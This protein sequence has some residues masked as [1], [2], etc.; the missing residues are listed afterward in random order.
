VAWRTFS[1]AGCG[2]HFDF[3]D[4]L[5]FAESLGPSLGS[6]ALSDVMLPPHLARHGRTGAWA[7]G[8]TLARAGFCTL[9]HTLRFL[10]LSASSLLLHHLHLLRRLL[11]LL[12]LHFAGEPAASRGGALKGWNWYPRSAPGGLGRA[13]ARIRR[14]V[15]PHRS[16]RLWRYGALRALR[17]Y[18]FLSHF[19]DTV[20]TGVA[21]RGQNGLLISPRIA[22]SPLMKSHRDSRAVLAQIL[23]A[24]M[25]T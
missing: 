20:L 13:C 10:E 18:F 23:A 8:R 17:F 21:I 2:T 12:L 9:L 7:H 24:K 6:I 15:C 19:D 3:F 5:P 16:G 11:L 1:V 4:Y 25:K 14:A 22:V